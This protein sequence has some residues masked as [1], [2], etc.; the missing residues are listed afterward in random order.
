MLTDREINE[1]AVNSSG[2]IDPAE[3][4]N[5]SFG[6]RDQA[7]A[8]KQSEDEAANKMNKTPKGINYATVDKSGSV[9]IAP[10]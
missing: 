5:V 8:K 7:P 4:T 9:K 3:I 1:V 6:G 10:K 2:T